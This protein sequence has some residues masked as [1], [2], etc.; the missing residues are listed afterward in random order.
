MRSMSHTNTAYT[1]NTHRGV[2]SLAVSAK[3]GVVFA[4]GADCR[5][6]AL[7]IHSG[8]EQASFKASKHPISCIA[9]APGRSR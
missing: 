4:A 5:V 8:A 6:C 2:S 9:L 3:Q 1:Q 7:D